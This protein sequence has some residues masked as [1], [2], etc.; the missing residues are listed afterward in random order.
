M[1]TCRSSGGDF[2]RR[3]CC[4]CVA[5]LD[6]LMSMSLSPPEMSYPCLMYFSCPPEVIVVMMWLPLL[7]YH[8]KMK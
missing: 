7:C 8:V 1:R 3:R 4:N 2:V 6:D 5:N